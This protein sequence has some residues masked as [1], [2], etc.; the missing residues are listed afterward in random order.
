MSF[1]V[2]VARL[3]G[4]LPS[5]EEARAHRAGPH[6]PG[7]REGCSGAEAAPERPFTGCRYSVAAADLI[8][9]AKVETSV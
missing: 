9:A 2:E 5:R 1:A 8:A 7:A 6:R 3:M 4:P